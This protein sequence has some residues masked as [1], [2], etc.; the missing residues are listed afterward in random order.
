MSKLR[1]E[2]VSREFAGVRGGAPT[3]ALEPINIT[4]GDNDFVTIL[5]PSGC[6]KSTLLRLVAG[7]DAPTTGRIAARR[8]RAHA[9]LHGNRAWFARLKA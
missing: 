7:L 2:N 4:I 3:R 1:I 9:R 5:G 8:R 6:G